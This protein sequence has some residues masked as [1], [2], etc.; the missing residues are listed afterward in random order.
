M[1]E[2]EI[3]IDRRLKTLGILT[4]DIYFAILND[5][6]GIARDKFYIPNAWTIT[7]TK[8]KYLGTL[9]DLDSTMITEVW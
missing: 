4:N 6:G 1:P 3:R 9:F 8:G 5:V 7:N 2:I